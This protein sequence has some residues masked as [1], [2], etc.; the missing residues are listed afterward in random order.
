[1]RIGKARQKNDMSVTHSALGNNVVSKMLHLGVTP[2]QDRD[3]ETTLVIKV[4]VQ[5]R[6]GEIV[7]FVVVAR[8]PLRQLAFLVIV[9]VKECSDAG[10]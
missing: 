7:M 2:L 3:F 5:C 1:M 10:P 6:L 8:E 9:D 4:Y